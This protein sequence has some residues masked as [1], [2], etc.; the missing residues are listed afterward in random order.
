MRGVPPHAPQLRALSARAPAPARAPAR[1]APILWRFQGGL[2][3]PPASINSRL[4]KRLESVFLAIPQ[5]AFVGVIS[6]PS[7]YLWLENRH[8]RIDH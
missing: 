2:E 8:D 5:R 3:R 1:A 6:R 7:S 4:E